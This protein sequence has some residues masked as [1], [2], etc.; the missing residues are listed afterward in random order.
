MR[1][2]KAGE[3]VE[4]YQWKAIPLDEHGLFWCNADHPSNGKQLKAREHAHIILSRGVFDVFPGD[5]I[6]A[7][8]D[9]DKRVY[10]IDEFGKFFT[11]IIK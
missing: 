11:R 8:K 7:D 3:T 6:T 9:G 1:Y 5:W 10:T 4:A 2:T